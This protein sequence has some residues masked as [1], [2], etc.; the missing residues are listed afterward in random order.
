M[1]N[2]S[3]YN[4]LIKVWW[5]TS[6]IAGCPK[7]EYAL[8][9]ALK[10]MGVFSHKQSKWGDKIPCLFSSATKFSKN[11]LAFLANI[12]TKIAF[13]VFD[14]WTL[15]SWILKIIWNLNPKLHHYN[16][17]D[18]IITLDCLLTQDHTSTSTR[19][20]KKFFSFSASMPVLE[21]LFLAVCMP[22]LTLLLS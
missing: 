13:L 20:E 12:T 7:G 4:S 22:L 11:R 17:P 10:T 6:S 18:I 21:S 2:S 9:H 3:K 1:H 5:S 15:W 8:Q 14:H 16:C 19:E